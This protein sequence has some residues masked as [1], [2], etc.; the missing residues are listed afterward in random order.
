MQDVTAWNRTPPSPR[1][2]WKLGRQHG[3][4]RAQQRGADFAMS[5]VTDDDASSARE[6]RNSHKASQLHLPQHHSQTPL[7]WR[8][9]LIPTAR[10]AQAL[11]LNGP[12]RP[13]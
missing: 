12:L 7:S 11:D 9:S 6:A 5:M 1:G 2:L 3:K 10:F 8:R 13:S 4:A